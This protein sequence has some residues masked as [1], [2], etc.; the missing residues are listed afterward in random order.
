M[1]DIEIT[2]LSNEMY[3]IQKF[4]TFYFKEYDIYRT[5][6]ISSCYFQILPSLG[7][8]GFVTEMVSNTGILLNVTSQ[9]LKVA[10]DFD[11]RVYSMVLPPTLKV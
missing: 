10:C 9:N 3:T 2:I 11:L 6:G 8:N 7:Q 1:Y 4:H 5:A